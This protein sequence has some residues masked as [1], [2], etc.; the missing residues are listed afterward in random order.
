MKNIDG[1]SVHATACLAEI[2]CRVLDRMTKVPMK[3]EQKVAKVT[4]AINPEAVEGGAA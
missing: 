4:A 3:D 2:L 1:T